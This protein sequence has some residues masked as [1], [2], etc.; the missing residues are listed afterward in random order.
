MIVPKAA[1]LHGYTPTA[2]GSRRCRD[3]RFATQRTKADQRALSTVHCRMFD[4]EAQ[5]LGVCDEWRKRKE[6]A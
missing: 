4:F 6:P 3:C 5:A 1:L 2:S